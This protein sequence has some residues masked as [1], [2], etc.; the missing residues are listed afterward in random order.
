MTSSSSFEDLHRRY[1]KALIERIENTVK[2]AP[3]VV[4][5]STS[6]FV[7]SGTA[8]AAAAVITHES[9]MKDLRETFIEDLLK[10]RGTNRN[11]SR[12]GETKQ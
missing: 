1:E 8:A 12:N 7:S 11:D 2:D 3:P 10:C 5:S 4:S 6:G 9:F